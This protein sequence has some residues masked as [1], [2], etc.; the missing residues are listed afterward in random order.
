AAYVPFGHLLAEVRGE[1]SR[2]V[3]LSIPHGH[4]FHLLDGW[5]VEPGFVFRLAV[6][7]DGHVERAD[8]PL[9]QRPWGA[10]FASDLKATELLPTAVAKG[11]RYGGIAYRDNRDDRRRE[12]LVRRGGLT[13][14]PAE[15]S[16]T[17]S[18]RYLSII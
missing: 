3:M 7:P 8:R 9:D 6:E 17:L 1:P 15:K 11:P 10:Q 5:V 12:H 4:A 18:G 16:H 14:A 2:D 13:V